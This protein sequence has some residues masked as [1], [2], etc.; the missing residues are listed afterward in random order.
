MLNEKQLDYLANL[1]RLNLTEE[2]KMKLVED[3]RQILGYVDQIK[4]ADITEEP[5]ISIFSSTILRDDGK[6][7]K[8]IHEIHD[9]IQAIKD[10]FPEITDEGYLKVPKVLTKE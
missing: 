4:K 2:E 10:N 5:L 6:S 3:L 7:R 1:A 9:T 8:D